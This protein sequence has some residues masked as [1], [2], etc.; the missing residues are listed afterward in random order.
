MVQQTVAV[1]DFTLET[2]SSFF[3]FFSLG[4]MKL[5]NNLHFRSRVEF[6]SDLYM[7]LQN[8]ESLSAVSNIVREKLL[9][10]ISDIFMR[11]AFEDCLTLD[12][13]KC[14]TFHLQCQDTFCLCKTSTL[15]YGPSAR[16]H[17]NLREYSFSNLQIL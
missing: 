12:N 8:F 1:Q 10:G 16:L 15:L 3:N 14:F 11:N 5:K 2:D 4:S 7:Q 9:C 13:L 6:G 17:I